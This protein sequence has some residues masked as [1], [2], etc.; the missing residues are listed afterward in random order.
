M[1][2]TFSHGAF[3]T[4]NLRPIED[5]ALLGPILSTPLPHGPMKG[6]S[7]QYIFFFTVVSSLI[8]ISFFASVLFKTLLLCLRSAPQHILLS[9]SPVG[10]GKTHSK[11]SKEKHNSTPWEQWFPK[12]SSPSSLVTTARLQP[13]QPPLSVIS[14][15]I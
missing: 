10:K 4:W 2:G 1:S 13:L 8:T 11:W 9:R 6:F 14:C 12:S 7:R 15:L 5:R 3:Y